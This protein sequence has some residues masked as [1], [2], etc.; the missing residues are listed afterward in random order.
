M[1][2]EGEGPA[3]ETQPVSVPVGP[4]PVRSFGRAPRSVRGATTLYRATRVQ[5]L[6]NRFAS[7]LALAGA[8]WTA[9]RG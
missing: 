3:R 6:L 5:V 2:A 4:G 9:P 1:E 7:T 8:G